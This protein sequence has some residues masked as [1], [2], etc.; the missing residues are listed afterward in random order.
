[1]I[2]VKLREAM[3]RYRRLTG[4]RMT[5]RQL[6]AAT[7]VSESTLQSIAAR[8]DYNTTL[9]TVDRIAVALDCPLD[10]LLERLTDAP[11][12]QPMLAAEG[13]GAT[14]GR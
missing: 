3:E 9:D 4:H 8:R 1:M 5:Y 7:G 12:E 13:D 2:A 14:D 6:A 10:V 11:S